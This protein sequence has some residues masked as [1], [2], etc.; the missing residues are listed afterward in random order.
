MVSVWIAP[1]AVIVVG[2]ME[3]TVGTGITAVTTA[4]LDVE[5]TSLLQPLEVRRRQTNHGFAKCDGIS[6]MGPPRT[7]LLRARL[8][9]I[10]L[11]KEKS[12][13]F[14]SA[15]GRRGHRGPRRR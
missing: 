10:G 12:S 13:A 1:S 14:C 4:D 3:L 7:I 11:P 2:E 5:R 6:H 9:N 15:Q 8:L